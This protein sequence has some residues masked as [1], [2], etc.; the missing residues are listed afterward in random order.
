MYDCNSSYGE[1]T[2]RLLT[3]NG[4]FIYLQT[5]GYLEIDKNT[6]KVH[7]FI[8]VNTLLD[9]EEGK[10]K[11][12]E[13]KNKFSVIINTKIPQNSIDAPAAENPLQLEKAVMCLIQNLQGSHSPVMASSSAAVGDRNPQTCTITEIAASSN[14]TKT[15]PLSLVPPEVSSVK[16]SIQQSVSVVNV[17]AAKNLREHQ[18][19][20]SLAN[21]S[22]ETLQAT[23]QQDD[24]ETI[25]SDL[26]GV[27]TKRSLTPQAEDLNEPV[28]KRRLTNTG[29]YS[30]IKQQFKFSI[31]ILCFGF[32]NRY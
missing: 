3:R 6:N 7:S 23:K 17:T 4:T 13:M 21:N 5:K 12:Q 28:A 31:Q 20:C 24:E 27:N 9:E 8:C 18:H 14:C 22:K 16:S 19:R 26:I 15:P 29:I 11:V 1:S 32:L 25:D 10:R 30:L 2:Y